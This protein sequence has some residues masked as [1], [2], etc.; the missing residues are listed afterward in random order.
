MNILFGAIGA[1]ALLVGTGRAADD[2]APA[3]NVR[4]T[5][6][7]SSQRLEKISGA[8]AT[9]TRT[10]SETRQEILVMSGGRARIQV[11]DQVPYADWFWTWGQGAG[12]W[13][14]QS[15]K[16]RDVGTRLAGE[17]EIMAVRTTRVRLAAGLSYSL[18][19]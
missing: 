18:A 5:V 3:R 16:S 11:A 6:F 15:V 2:K 8:G 17:N 10:T 13:P 1:L 19:S 7:H 4:I 12:L 9:K 14:A